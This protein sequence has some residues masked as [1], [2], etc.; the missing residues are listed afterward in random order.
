MQPKSVCLCLALVLA[1]SSIGCSGHMNLYLNQHEVMRFL[2]ECIFRDND[3]RQ[4]AM[5]LVSKANSL[6]DEDIEGEKWNGKSFVSENIIS[7]ELCIV[8]S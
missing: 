1:L 3:L 7:R 8:L 6:C 2:G 4:C 5:Q